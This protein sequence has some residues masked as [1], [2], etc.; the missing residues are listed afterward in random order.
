MI[1]C[2]SSLWLTYFEGTTDASLQGINITRTKRSGFFSQS[3]KA[4]LQMVFS[5]LINNCMTNGEKSLGLLGPDSI[6]TYL[7]TTTKF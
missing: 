6:L 1:S 7:Y 4:A 5:F 3:I 2:V